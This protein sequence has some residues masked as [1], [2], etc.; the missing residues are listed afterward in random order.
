MKVDIDDFALSF[1]FLII[2]VC[3][4]T[5]LNHVFVA[6]EMLRLKIGY[7]KKFLVI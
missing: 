7:E 6:L 1:E 3:G 4:P 2:L 5:A